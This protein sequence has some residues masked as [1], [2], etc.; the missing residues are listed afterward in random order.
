[1]ISTD[2][3]HQEYIPLERVQN[4]IW[5]AQEC[6]IPYYVSLV[7]ENESDAAYLQINAEILKSTPPE[8]IRTGI[9][10]PVGRA[11]ELASELRYSLDDHSPKGVCQAAS[12]P[13]IFPDGKVYGCIGPLLELRHEHPLLLGS[14]R[15]SPMP[16]IFDRA[17]TNVV[18]HA[19][20]LWGPQ[21]LISMLQDAGLGDR[22]PRQYVAG[23]ICNACYSMLSDAVVR[24]WL[25]QLEVDTEFRRKVAYGRLYHLDEPAMLEMCG[26]PMLTAAD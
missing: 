18:L 9:T 15:A 20:R 6:G 21:R 17:E 14:L 2:V 10:F 19:L 4:V 25:A 26:F 13:C 8:N 3:Y 22:L 11:S 24:K 12:S 1:L 7:T 5:A 23:S 16:E